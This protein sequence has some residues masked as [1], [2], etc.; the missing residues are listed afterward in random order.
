[1]TRKKEKERHNRAP[2]SLLPSELALTTLEAS[3]ERRPSL[4]ART[5]RIP[6]DGA[7]LLESGSARVLYNKG[8]SRDRICVILNYTPCNAGIIS[9]PQARRLAR[10][11]GKC[12]AI[13]RLRFC[14]SR[15][16]FAAENR[17]R[18]LS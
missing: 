17:E 15:E 16:I 6:D 12:A 9:S 1:M 18:V 7:A 3:E 8:D 2:T 4:H 13:C 11:R 10:S 5:I 14:A